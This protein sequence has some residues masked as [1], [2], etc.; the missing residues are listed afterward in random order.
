MNQI[1][2]FQ[3]Y[4]WRSD[5]PHIRVPG[6]CYSTESGS[7]R[8]DVLGTFS[9]KPLDPP[10]PKLGRILGITEKG[11]AITLEDCFFAKQRYHS[12]GWPVSTI[13][14]HFALLGH[15]FEK[16]DISLEEILW[17]SDAIDE[18]LRIAP[19]ATDVSTNP[20]RVTISFSPELSREWP[21][22][23][24]FLRI[25]HSWSTSGSHEYREAKLSKRVWVGFRFAETQPLN[26][27]VRAANRF[28]KFVSLAVDQIIPLDSINVLSKGIVETIGKTERSIPIEVYYEP[29]SRERPDLSRLSQPLLRFQNLETRFGD[30][31]ANWFANYEKFESAFN[32]YFATKSGRELYVENRFLML[33]QALEALH[34]GLSVATVFSDDEYSNFCDV[35]EAAAPPKF[36]EWLQ[37]RL[38]YGNEPSLRRRLRELFEAFGAFYGQPKH[39]DTWVSRIVDARNYA[40][41]H[42]PELKLRAARGSDLL[43]LCDVLETLIQLHMCLLCGLSRDEVVKATGQSEAL[44]H[45]LAPVYRELGK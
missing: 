12:R 4:F 14:A 40:T 15:H 24:G 3:G 42:D 23:G 21:I 6:K 11:V 37:L 10:E 18:W 30:V 31:I 39:I 45:K 8:L 5:A 43:E 7:I 2:P 25:G 41:H 38:K 44:A 28:G 34:R 22:P 9:G 20:T 32:L 1:T 29:T 33:I 36:R 26:D 35:L 13:R 16:V 27:L 17:Q 19:I